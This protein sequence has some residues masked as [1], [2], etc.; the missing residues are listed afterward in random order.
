MP[1]LRGSGRR[2]TEAKKEDG[3]KEEMAQGIFRGKR[4]GEKEKGTDW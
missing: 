4:E 2:Q 3:G 1:Y